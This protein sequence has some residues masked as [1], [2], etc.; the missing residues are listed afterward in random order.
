[1]PEQLVV[2]E[3]LERDIVAITL[4]RPEKRNAL[5]IPLLDALCKAIEDAHMRQ[6]R[7][8]VLRGAGPVFCA[9]LD[10]AEAADPTNAQASA[11]SIA[12]ALESVM[13]SR[14]V[15]IAAV[16]GAAVA[17]GAGLMSA[18]DIVVAEE[19]ARIG[20]P[21]V[22]RGLVA[23]LVMTV[24]RR[25]LRERDARELLLL[26]ELVDAHRAK[27]V[28]LVNRVV[29]RGNA[30]DTA[31]NLAGVILKGAPG[32][33]AHSKQMLNDLWPKPLENDLAWALNQHKAVRAGREAREGIAA[34]NEKRKP[35]WD[36]TP[37]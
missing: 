14:A 35:N 19:D 10:L 31:L 1:M 2:V 32:A 28:G 27:D 8:I 36:T 23:G 34:F 12:Q 3:P 29:P 16:H 15:T 22:R 33:L 4:N 24:L 17:G 26:G 21:E 20:Y 9:G 5:N 6:A 7:V 25:Q 30:F 11:Q 18:C 37:E 13:Q